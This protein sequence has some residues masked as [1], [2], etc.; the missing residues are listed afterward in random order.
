MRKDEMLQSREGT[1]EFDAAY[2]SRHS[3]G[4]PSTVNSAKKKLF[5]D[6]EA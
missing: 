2:R 5:E 3:L 1:D 6:G 4:V